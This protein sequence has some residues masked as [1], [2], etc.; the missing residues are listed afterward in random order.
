MSPK[1]NTSVTG[2]PAHSSLIQAAAAAGVRI[3]SLGKAAS[4]PVV[5]AAPASS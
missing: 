2:S 3:R 4:R 5:P 1:Q